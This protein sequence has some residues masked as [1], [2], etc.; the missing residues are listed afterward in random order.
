MNVLAPT[1]PAHHVFIAV[2]ACFMFQVRT[3]VKLEDKP[4]FFHYFRTLKKR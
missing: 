2:T 4:N 3:V 1:V